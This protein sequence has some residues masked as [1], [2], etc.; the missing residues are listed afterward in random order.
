LLPKVLLS[1]GI[2]V[3]FGSTAPR[4]KLLVSGEVHG[5]GPLWTPPAAQI[6]L[7]VAKR[8]GG[9]ATRLVD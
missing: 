9:K 7:C 6:S 2:C 5:R 4:A 1:A 3:V 8:F